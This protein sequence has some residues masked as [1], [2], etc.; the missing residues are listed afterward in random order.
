MHTEIRT[1]QEVETGAIVYALS[2]V[3]AV[4]RMKTGRKDKAYARS[5]WENEPTRRL[6]WSANG[7]HMFAAIL[8]E[9][10]RDR[11]AEEARRWGAEIAAV[12]QK[13]N[14]RSITLSGS[15]EKIP[16]TALAEG[17]L[18]AG[19]RFNKYFKDAEKKAFP[20]QLLQLS[21]VSEAE[22]ARLR[23][24]IPAVYCGRD[25]INEP[26]NVLNAEALANRTKELGK[27]HGFSVEVFNKRKIESLK[28][29]GLL[30][31]NRGSIDPPTFTVL[32]YKPE[33]P[34]NA[35]PL[36]LV[37]KGIVYDTGGLS[38]KPTAGS[39]D[40]MKSDMSGAAA[41]IGTFAA[42][43]GM[44]LPVHLIGLIPA[45]DN[46]PGGNAYTPGDI[47]T[48]MDGTTVEVLNTDAE[49]RMVLADALTYAKRYRPE[50]VIN[51]ATLTGA[52]AVAIGI[53][54]VVAM[55][56]AEEKE[57]KHLEAAGLEVHERLAR[58]PFWPEYKDQL[59]SSVADLKNIG[60]REAGA[61]TAGKFLEHF[62][63]YPFI[64]LDIAGPAFLDNQDH[65]RV[66]GG[67]GVGIRLLTEFIR[68]RIN[69]G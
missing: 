2:G 49:G 24:L 47:I 50:L 19:Y 69:H 37:G 65:Y 48:M 44:Q 56:N 42:V 35:A 39:M 38:L 4:S 27:T 1:G 52:A 18:L 58:F 51:L 7:T 41:V 64:H 67:T 14:I 30:A 43:A 55:G 68:K 33:K 16:V 40:S 45:T 46:R 3:K 54:G 9:P 25:L 32:E 29:G 22:A 36:L 63:D 20:L 59:K 12:I 26:V 11:L 53:Q 10:K 57:W 66:K 60:G 8:A 5:V 61:I 17:I 34:V 6:S 15:S 62:T 31:V 13:E 28:M 21:G 23:A